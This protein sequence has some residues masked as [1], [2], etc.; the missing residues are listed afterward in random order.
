MN[1]IGEFRKDSRNKTKEEKDA[2]QEDC[3]KV[4][5]PSAEAEY[6]KLLAVCINP[7][8]TGHKHENQHSHI[9]Y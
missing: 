7:G 8:Y 6:R 3:Q 1:N 2:H 4:R 5:S 9:F